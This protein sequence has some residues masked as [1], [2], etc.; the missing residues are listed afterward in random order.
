SRPGA[1]PARGRPHA[2]S[3]RGGGLPSRAPVHGRHQGAHG[4]LAGPPA[5]LDLERERAVQAACLA[6]IEAGCV[7]SAHDCAEG[8]LAV[9]LAECCITAP[10]PLG[11]E[12]TL[13]PEGRLDELLFGEAPSRIVLTV[14]PDE[15]SR[16]ERI[17]REWAVPVAAL[18]RV[19]GDRLTIR[20]GDR[21][22]VAVALPAM[23]DAFTRVFERWVGGLAEQ[24]SE[25]AA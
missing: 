12:I 2:G 6:A 13:D 5:P 22:G 8:G 23:R 20:V 11:A 24:P 14:A 7:R 10:R 18:G 4:R 1:P 19:G 17:V 16:F 15:W 9:A 3:Q 21:V 25:G